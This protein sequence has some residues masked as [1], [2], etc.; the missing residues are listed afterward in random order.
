MGHHKNFS[1]MR[2]A[3]KLSTLFVL[4]FIIC[5]IWYW[6]NPAEQALHLAL[7]KMKFF[8]FSGMNIT[9]FIS[10]FIQVII[11]GHIVAALLLIS[12]KACH[13]KC[14]KSK[15]CKE[16]EEK[17]CCKKEERVEEKKEYEH[18]EHKE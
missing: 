15:C 10:G 16:G 9:S 17:N 2:L 1:F 18:H 4:L 6:I 12:A 11:W 3:H 13:G 8:A 7:F 14:C 5:F